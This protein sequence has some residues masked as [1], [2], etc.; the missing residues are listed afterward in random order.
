MEIDQRFH[1]LVAKFCFLYLDRNQ[2]IDIDQT[3]IQAIGTNWTEVGI[4]CWI[5]I[6]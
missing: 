2:G 4:L 3:Q 6:T 5:I 1:H